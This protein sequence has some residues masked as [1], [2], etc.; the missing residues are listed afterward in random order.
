[1]DELAITVGRITPTDPTTPQSSRMMD[2][3]RVDPTIRVNQRTEEL[4]VIQNQVED[5][6]LNSDLQLF[7]SGLMEKEEGYNVSSFYDK[8]AVLL[9]SWD[10]AHDDL[11]TKDEVVLCIT[12]S[13]TNDCEAY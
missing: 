13:W 1:M 8:V 4:A 3:P 5:E 11:K 2:L 9:I 6:K 7:W 10:E 12:A